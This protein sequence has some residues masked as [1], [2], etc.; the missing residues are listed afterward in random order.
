M[1]EVPVAITAVSEERLDQYSLEG[2]MD[3]EA[4]TP[5]LSIFRGSS[6]NGASLAIRG[7]GSSISSIGIESSTAV[8]IDREIAS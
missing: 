6:G 8:I 3:L 1:R 4:I 5:Q 7:I 2:F